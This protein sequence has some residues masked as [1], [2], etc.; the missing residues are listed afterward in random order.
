MEYDQV[1]LSPSLRH[2]HFLHV[3][4]LGANCERYFEA[5]LLCDFACILCICIRPHYL[6]LSRYSLHTAYTLLVKV[7]GTPCT[8]C[9]CFKIVFLQCAR[10][11]PV[12]YRSSTQLQSVEPCLRCSGVITKLYGYTLTLQGSGSPVL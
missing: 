11:I 7:K 6:V 10:F 8:G 4:F 1:H 9:N 3:P 5:Y 2:F 12:E